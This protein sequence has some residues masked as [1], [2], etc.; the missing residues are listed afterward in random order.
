MLPKLEK[1]VDKSSSRSIPVARFSTENT[2]PEPRPNTFSP[3]MPGAVNSWSAR[4]SMKAAS[5]LGASMKSSALRVGG[6]SS[7]SRS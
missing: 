3:R 5:F 4:E 2:R 1:K 7:T 6:V